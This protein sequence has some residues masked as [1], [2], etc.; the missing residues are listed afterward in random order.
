[1]LRKP[2]LRPDLLSEKEGYLET[3]I[4]ILFRLLAARSTL[5]YAIS[6]NSQ[7]ISQMCPSKSQSSSSDHTH[8]WQFCFYAMQA[9]T[10]L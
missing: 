2:L 9:S 6:F 1:M 7:W 10:H 8:M 3:E 5:Y 4:T